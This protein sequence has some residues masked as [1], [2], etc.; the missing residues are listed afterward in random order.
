MRST[1]YRFYKKH[2]DLW[3]ETVFK[4]NRRYIPANHDRYFDNEIMVE[5]NRQMAKENQSM[6][7]LIDCLV[8]KDSLQTTLWYMDWTFFITVSY[9]ADRSKKSCYRMMTSYFDALVK[10]FSGSTEVRLFFTTEKYALRK[11]FHNHVALYISNPKQREAITNFTYDFF[12]YDRID[13]EAYNKYEAG[14]FYM[15]KEGL[16]NEDWDILFT[17]PDQNKELSELSS[18]GWW[19]T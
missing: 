6:R 11:G 14:L 13:F 2:E 15:C 7:K 12:E 10:K 8:D 17:N 3:E 16:V 1:L 4:H 9:K 18:V 19:T 5:E